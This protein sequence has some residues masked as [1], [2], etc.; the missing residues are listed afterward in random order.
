MSQ[1]QQSMTADQKLDLIMNQMHTD[2]QEA[3]QREQELLQRIERLT[4]SKSIAK[5]NNIQEVLDQAAHLLEHGNTNNGGN[6][7]VEISDQW[8]NASR[9]YR[10]TSNIKS[11]FEAD[12]IDEEEERLARFAQLLSKSSRQNKPSTSN[13]RKCSRCG[14]T[15]H[16]V[17]KCFS[18]T[19]LDG[20]KLE[21]K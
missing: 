3:I 9:A 11:A 19:H 21:D 4:L 1:Q 15:S 2:K 16:T 8:S 7:P 5:P 20:T 18:K 6:I 12:L 13:P 10:I 17:S 14:R